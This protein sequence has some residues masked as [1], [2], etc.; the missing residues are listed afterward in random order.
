[1]F[2]ID[3]DFTT[4][5]IL[6]CLIFYYIEQQEL[7][8]FVLET[9]VDPPNDNLLWQQAQTEKTAVDVFLICRCVVTY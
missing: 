7:P 1:M 6:N 9:E 2:L 8:M 4:R 3:N 5:D